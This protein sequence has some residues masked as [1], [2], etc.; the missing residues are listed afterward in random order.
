MGG[1]LVKAAAFSYGLN[2][3]LRRRRR[4][5]ALEDGR[6]SARGRRRGRSRR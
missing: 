1:P 3:A 4:T 2:K 6:H 5:A